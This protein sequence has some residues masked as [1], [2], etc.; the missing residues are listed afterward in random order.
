M[1]SKRRTFTGSLRRFL[2]LRDPTC[3]VPF[4]DAPA[5]HIDHATGHAHGAKTDAAEGNGQCANHN[6]IKEA[7][8]WD[9]HIINNGLDPGPEHQP[10][11]VQIT[12]PTGR[13]IRTRAAPIHGWGAHGIRPALGAT[14]PRLP[15]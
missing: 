9:H 1:D 5:I 7:P 6:L 8:G 11:E 14:G 13:I 10:H 4:C 15:L 12:T 2:E 3:R